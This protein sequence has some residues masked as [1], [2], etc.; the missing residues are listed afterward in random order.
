MVGME[1]GFRVGQNNIEFGGE[2][3]MKYLEKLWAMTRDERYTCPIIAA[4]CVP[5]TFYNVAVLSPST[6]WSL[7]MVGLNVLMFIIAAGEDDE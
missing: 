5:L 1:T 6:S 4:S 3:R 7:A 2:S